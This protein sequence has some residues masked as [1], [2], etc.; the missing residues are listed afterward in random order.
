MSTQIE[1]VFDDTKRSGRVRVLFTHPGKWGD[2]LWAMAS[3]FDFW[4]K[5]T[6][7][8]ER[9]Q[10]DVAVP[11]QY[12]SVVSLLEA[13]PYVHHAFVHPTWEVQEGAPNQPWQAPAIEG[14]HRTFNLGLAAW[15]EQ[16]LP[17]A[18]AARHGQEEGVREV[19][20]AGLWLR[21]EGWNWRAVGAWQEVVSIACLFNQQWLE[22]KLGVVY[23][24]PSW[25]RSIRLYRN[26]MT[27]PGGKQ[28]KWATERTQPGAEV[29]YTPT[30]EIGVHF[31]ALDYLGIAR[32]LANYSLCL[33]DRSSQWVL[34]NGLGLPTI[35]IEP[36]KDRLDPRFWPADCAHRN[37]QVGWNVEEV[38][39]AV[40]SFIKKHWK[41]G[42]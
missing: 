26:V 29:A 24:L 20:K 12:G 5:A 19:L 14:Y 3:V 9:V 17:L 27:L 4:S 35:V 30:E 37:V 32:E 16:E 40:V 15:P 23:G 10:V 11:R 41:E 8:G 34:A 33:T 39:D 18:I 28:L 6:A 31:E 22:L 42:K 38:Q 21:P 25:L 2:I 36:D 1:P 7:A 13:L